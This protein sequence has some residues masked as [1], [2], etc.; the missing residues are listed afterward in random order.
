MRGDGVILAHGLIRS[1]ASMLAPYIHLKRKGYDV[2]LYSY[3]S[4]RYFLDEHARRF[5][6]FIA[7]FTEQRQG[8]TI[9]FVTHSLGGIIMRSAVDLLVREGTGDIK[10]GRA[11]M[12]APPNR[13]SNAA[14]RISKSKII[15]TALKPLRELRD[16]PDSAIHSIPIPDVLEYGIIAGRWDG[17]VSVNEARLGCEK[18]FLVVNSFHTFLMNRP[19]VL[20]AS[21]KFIET[22][23]FRS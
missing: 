6:D 3:R 23:S 12:L 9:H 18:D 19:D 8:G 22:G 16:S 7:N 20:R 11:V 1:R 2:K 21:V 4:T 17:K 13:G 10:F 15:S 14:T 5:A